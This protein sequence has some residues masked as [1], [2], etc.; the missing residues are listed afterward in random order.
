MNK[1]QIMVAS[2]VGA[3]GV[4]AVTYYLSKKNKQDR[5]STLDYAGMPDQARESDLAQLENSKMVSE[6]SQFGVQYYNHLQSEH[7]AMK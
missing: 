6:G 7:E 2:G 3:L 4:A 1:G 5:T